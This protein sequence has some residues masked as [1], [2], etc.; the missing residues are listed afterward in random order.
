MNVSCETASAWLESGQITQ[1]EY[2]LLTK[3]E[4]KYHARKTVVDGIKFHSAKEARRYSELKMLEKSGGI[5]DLK[6]QV[7]FPLDVQGVHICNYVCDFHYLDIEKGDIVVE[8]SK[9]MRTPEY[10][11]KRKL[12]L[13]IYGIEILET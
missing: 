12:M 4:S 6:L 2:E 8:D 11:L 5:R 9:G 1:E 10:K 13:A 7:K 3:K